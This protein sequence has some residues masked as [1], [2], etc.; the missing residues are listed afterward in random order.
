MRRT[1]APNTCAKYVP[2][3]E[4]LKPGSEVRC[5]LSEV[6]YRLSLRLTG[7]ANTLER[8]MPLRDILESCLTQAYRPCKELKDSMTNKRNKVDFF[9]NESFRCRKIKATVTFLLLPTIFLVSEFS[10]PPISNHLFIRLNGTKSLRLHN[11]ELSEIISVLTRFEN[12][13]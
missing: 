11:K 3:S 7:T 4:P 6:W 9:L 8:A 5:R 13:S 10:L 2:V 12:R 1:R